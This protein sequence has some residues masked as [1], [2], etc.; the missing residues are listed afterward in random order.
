M[1]TKQMKVSVGMSGIQVYACLAM[2]ASAGPMSAQLGPQPGTAQMSAPAQPPVVQMGANNSSYQ[3]SV[4]QGQATA[5]PIDLSLR[6]AIQRGLKTNLGILNSAQSSVNVRAQRRRVLSELMPN[7]TGNFTENY[8]RVNLAAEGFKLPANSPVQI[9]EIVTFPSVDT[10]ASLTQSVFDLTRLRNLRSADASVRASRLDIEDSRDLVVQAVGNAYLL[11]ISDAARVDSIKAQ[12]D[13]SQTLFQRATDQRTAG[14]APAIDQLRAE[15]QLRT[16]QQ[17]LLS[18]QNQ[19]AKDK[20]S[21]GRVI[22]LP[23]GQQFNLTDTLPFAPLDAMGTDQALQQAYANRADF[24]AAQEQLRAAELSRSAAV[25]QYYPTLNVS[26][27]FGD[28]GSYLTSSHNVFGVTGAVQ[29]NIFS[30]GRIKSEI[31]QADVALQ[32]QKDAIGDLR[33]RIDQE[34][35]SAL[36]DLQS[37]ADQVAVARRNVDLAHQTLTQS[38]DRFTA[39]VTDNVEVVQAQQ[40]VVTADANLINA[41]YQHNLAKIELARSLGLTE[42]NLTKFVGGNK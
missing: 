3:G 13:T 5:A 41:T 27:N 31:E 14:T 39:G 24:K 38:R 36:L 10:R 7:V 12:V 37:A 26:G 23:P 18:A 6:D 34:V 25:A 19:L 2:V 35:R 20:I 4:A 28:A 17:S 22:G 40:S 15:V 32:Q 42:Q 16:D 8:Q 11:I 29:F 30:G 1:N 33:G 21:L 9:P